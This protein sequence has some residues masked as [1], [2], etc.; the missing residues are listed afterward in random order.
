MTQWSLKDARERFAEI[1]SAAQTEPQVITDGNTRV[2]VRR[3]DDVRPTETPPIAKKVMYKGK[4]MG[5]GDLLRA[6]PDR[7]GFE[8]ERVDIIMRDIDF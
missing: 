1:Y 5:L 3:E 4:P 2:T 8:I 7:E 6:M